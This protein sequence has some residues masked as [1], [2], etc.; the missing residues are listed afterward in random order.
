M[1]GSWS[2]VH[3]DTKRLAQ[4]YV[5][6]FNDVSRDPS[7]SGFQDR[8][9]FS[10]SINQT[11]FMYRVSSPTTMDEPRTRVPSAPK[12]SNRLWAIARSLPKAIKL[13][14]NARTQ[15]GQDVERN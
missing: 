14:S 1:E 5:R 13:I 15:T 3:W 4:K 8:I 9:M 2:P 10:F 12:E 11:A 7:Q 6:G